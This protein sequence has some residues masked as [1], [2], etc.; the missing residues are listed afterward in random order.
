[1]K[2]NKLKIK[3]DIFFNFIF[4]SFFIPAFVRA[5]EL[6]ENKE[7]IPG[8]EPTNDLVVYLNNLYN[9]GIAIAAI[10]A[11]FMIAMGAFNYI[12]TSAGNAS[13]V[14][15]AKDMIK[16][17]LFGLVLVFIAF[18]LLYIINPDLVNGTILEP[19]KLIEQI[20]K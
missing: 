13:K 20:N 15:D 12:V 19:E 1:M 17:A 7:L 11:I 4:L 6:Y 5:G 9:F 2:P 10:L 16:N 3:V 8:Q 18:L 14:I